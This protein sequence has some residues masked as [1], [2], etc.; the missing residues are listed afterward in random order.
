MKNNRQKN[1][2]GGG[3]YNEKVEYN[4]IRNLGGGP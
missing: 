4:L 3:P 1:Y 2:L